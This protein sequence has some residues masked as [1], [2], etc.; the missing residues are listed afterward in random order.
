[1]RKL[2]VFFFAAGCGYHAAYAGDAPRLHVKLVRTLVADVVASDEVA[3]G[4]RDELARGGA[5][6]A[7]VGYPR[8][9][10]EVLRADEVSEGTRAAATG[11]AARGLDVGL[12]ARAWIVRS[13]GAAPERDTGDMRAEEVISVDA[14]GG[15]ALDPRA[16]AFHRA[17]ALRAAARRL[18]RALGARLMGHPAASEEAP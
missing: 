5:L 12:A 18:G 2:F 6:E 13:L 4:V 10:I 1:V 11:P 3:A 9:E 7:G 15:G 16:A 14:N 17:D 8:I